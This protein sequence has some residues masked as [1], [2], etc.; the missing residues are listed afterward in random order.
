MKR[1]HAVFTVH[2]SHGQFRVDE[3]GFVVSRVDESGEL[4][5]VW[6]FEAS[7][8]DGRTKDVDILTVGYWLRDARGGRGDYERPLTADELAWRPRASARGTSRG[9]GRGLSLISGPSRRA[10]W[11][12]EYSSDSECCVTRVPAPGWLVI[13]KRR[14]DLSARSRIER[15]SRWPGNRRRYRSRALV[16]NLEVQAGGG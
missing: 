6:R 11:L 2:S 5:N 8:W 15:R 3:D 13:S 7:T 12:T 10:G 14:A 16:G 9:V 1:D 4:P